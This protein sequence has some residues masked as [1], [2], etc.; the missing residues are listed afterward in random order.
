MISIGRLRLSFVLLVLLGLMTPHFGCDRAD[1]PKSVREA[2]GNGENAAQQKIHS[3]NNM[4]YIGL[5]IHNYA[6]SMKAFPPAYIADKTGKPLLSWRVLILP[7]LDQQ[8]L[9]DQFH[10]N[11]PWDSEHNK[12]LLSQMPDVYKTPGNSVAGQWKTNYLAVRGKDTVISGPVPN[13]FSSVKDGTSKRI[14]I[15]E[16]TDARAV[17]WTR[18]D[19]FEFNPQNPSDGLVGLRENCFLAVAVDGGLRFV[20]TPV[21]NE[22]L[23]G[24]FNKSDGNSVDIEE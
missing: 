5:D 20:K 22:V 11:E 16:V 6:T 13:H 3:S 17:E 4:K 14:M 9:Y 2:V 15:V 21:L 1:L 19:D 10:L 23:L 7:F 18:P 24:W 12:K 8:G